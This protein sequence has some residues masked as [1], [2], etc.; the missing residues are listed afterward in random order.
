MVVCAVFMVLMLK[1]QHTFFFYAGRFSSSAFGT[2]FQTAQTT[3]K[4]LLADWKNL[5]RKPERLTPVG[6]MSA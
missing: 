1:T 5:L 4:T 3:I 6:I 2:C